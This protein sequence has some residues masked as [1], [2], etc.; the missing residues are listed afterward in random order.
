MEEQV[1]FQPAYAMLTLSLAAGE[2]VRVEPGAMVAQENV[3]METKSS[4]GFFKGLKKMAFGGESF[5][6]NTF[7]GGAGGGWISL[8]PSAPGDLA[9]FDVQPGR[10][11]YIQSGSFMASASNVQT[12][13]QFQGLKGAF[14]GESMFFIRAYTEDGMPGRVYYNSYGAIKAIPVQQGQTVT[15][16]TGHVVAFEDTL[17]YQIGKVGGMKSFMFGGEGLVMNFSGQGSIWIQTRNVS[18]LAGMIIPFIPTNN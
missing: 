4:G 6:L 15:V 2:A 10:Q 7:T 11:L 13:T 3:T 17:Q 16:D 8:A 14:S 9:W 18:A 12:D 1:E 5:F